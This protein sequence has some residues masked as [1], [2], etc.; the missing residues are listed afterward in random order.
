MQG[1]WYVINMRERERK[2]ERVVVSTNTNLRDYSL[3]TDS[4]IDKCSSNLS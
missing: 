2:R 1:Y 3:I 4:N